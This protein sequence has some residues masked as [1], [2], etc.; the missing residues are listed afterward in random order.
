MDY[1]G[2]FEMIGTLS[3]VDQIRTTHKRFKN[4]INYENYINNIDEI[5][6]AE[7]A[8]FNCFI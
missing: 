5:N 3:V 1:A 7:D 8:I 4:V 6:D 2:E